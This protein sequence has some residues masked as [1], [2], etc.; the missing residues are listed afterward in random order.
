M[1]ALDS[2]ESGGIPEQIQA[3]EVPF[4]PSANG[5]WRTFRNR[6][7]LS[8]RAREYRNEVLSMLDAESPL[9]GL[10]HVEVDL[11][12]PD[13]RRRD[14]DNYLKSLLDALTH[15]GVYGDDSQIKKL[16]VT[17]MDPMKGGKAC[18]RLRNA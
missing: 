8:K 10:L 5:Y 11:Y 12:P 3:L 9:M 15:A 13:R 7:I 18:L 2:T 6:Q 17:M 4:P 14:V 16:T 1:E